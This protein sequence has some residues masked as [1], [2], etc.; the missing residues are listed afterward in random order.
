MPRCPS[1]VNKAEIDQVT[2]SPFSNCSA[3]LCNLNCCCRNSCSGYPDSLPCNADRPALIEPFLSNKR[4]ETRYKFNTRHRLRHIWPCL[5]GRTVSWESMHADVKEFTR[6]CPKAGIKDEVKSRFFPG[7]PS[8][9]L[10]IVHAY[11]REPGK[12]LVSHSST[13][14]W[15]FEQCRLK[16]SLFGPYGRRACFTRSY[17]AWFG[18]N[19]GIDILGTAPV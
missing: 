3:G 19:L 4:C 18:Q 13:G 7:R 15:D 5:L 10:H 16:S 1:W 14:E 6:R 2:N 17:P 12:R 8:S 11:K 9:R